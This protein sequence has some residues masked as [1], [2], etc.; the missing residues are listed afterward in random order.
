MLYN[1]HHHC[2]YL[3]SKMASHSSDLRIICPSFPVSWS[4]Y[5]FRMPRRTMDWLCP[6]P[7]SQKILQTKKRQVRGLW[8]PG[9]G[10]S[11]L[12][13]SPTGDK[14]GVPRPLDYWLQWVRVEEGAGLGKAY[15]QRGKDGAGQEQGQHE[16]VERTLESDR[17]GFESQLSYALDLLP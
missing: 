4:L 1:H 15:F 2:R 7:L 5:P 13:T 8:A 10:S 16:V 6:P 14:T 3:S 9:L 12:P 17:P 11:I